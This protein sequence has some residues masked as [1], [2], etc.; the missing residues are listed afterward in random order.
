[1][2][3]PLDRRDRVLPSHINAPIGPRKEL[4]RARKP[5]VPLLTRQSPRDAARS[6][7]DSYFA[8]RQAS[9]NGFGG[10]GAAGEVDDVEGWADEE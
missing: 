8:P 6:R 1:M 2:I 7:F 5:L 10:E 9:E 4:W 3:L